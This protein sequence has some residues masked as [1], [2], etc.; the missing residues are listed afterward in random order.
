MT[1]STSPQDRPKKTLIIH[2]GDHKTG[3][4][5]IQNAFAAGRV[6]L[7]EQSVI[8]PGTLD[9]NYLS[10]HVKALAAGKP[11]P[12]SRPDMPNLKRIAEQ[13][14]ESPAEVCLLSGESFESVPPEA[15][16]SALDQIF[17][18]RFPDLK[19]RI[20]VYIRPHAGRLLSTFTEQTKIGWYQGDL[21]TMF[22]RTLKSKRFFFV[23]RLQRWRSVFG[24]H[25]LIRPMV[26]SELL[27]GSVVDDFV[28]TAFDGQPFEIAAGATGNE[29]VGLE[30]LMLI[31]HVQ[32]H[33]AQ[34]DKGARLGFGWEIAQRISATREDRKATKLQ[35]PKGLAQRLRSSYLDDAR[36]LDSEFFGNRGLFEAD[37]DKAVETASPKRQSVNPQ[38]Y[39][40][41][42][43]LRDIA[44]LAET[45]AG[46][47]GRS[48]SNWAYWFRT[49]RAETL[50]ASPL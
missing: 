18:S 19:L 23:P 33:L 44:L 10:E 27:N 6:T 39:F 2:I 22:Q 3:S 28:H 21:Q 38:D 41:S 8:Y 25:L 26:R 50:H 17:L 16:R 37:L 45:L 34:V 14:A 1:N 5:S 47:L 12:K 9:H 29:S 11:G 49:R 7:P 31:K 20:I 36:T 30:D 40:S 4:T 46:M 15:L 42:R 13:M 24:D 48:Q 35:L 43:E 32:A